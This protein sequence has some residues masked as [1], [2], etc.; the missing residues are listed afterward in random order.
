MDTPAPTYTGLFDEQWSLL[1]SPNSMAAVDSPVAYLQAL[2]A[3]AL[4]LESTGTE[5]TPKIKLEARRP[6]LTTLNIDEQSLTALV[7]QRSV[8]NQMLADR[9]DAFLKNT[10]GRYRAKPLYARH[11]RIHRL[12]RRARRFHAPPAPLEPSGCVHSK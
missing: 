5:S 11:R 10:A 4:A 9:L 1:C 8:V 3:F 6:D 12:H 2:Y 7:P